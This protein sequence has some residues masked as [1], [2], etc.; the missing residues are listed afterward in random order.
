[1]NAFAHQD[2]PSDVL[3][4]DLNIAR[5]SSRNPLFDTMFIYQ[6][7]GFNKVDLNGI[8]AHICSPTSHTSKFDISLE[9]M[10]VKDDTLDIYIEYCTRLF[11]QE[12]VEN[13]AEHYI[14]IL[15]TIVKKSEIKIKEIN[16]LT[17]KE[18]MLI[19]E[20]NNTHIINTINTRIAVNYVNKTSGF[21]SEYNKENQE[22][23]EQKLE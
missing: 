9:I 11:D 3:V 2:Y 8:N 1:M 14:S 6:N 23:N 17:E 12:Y 13:F 19:Q 7:N 16:I 15:N 18:K 22:S 10:P 21:L 5:D 20:F 4:N